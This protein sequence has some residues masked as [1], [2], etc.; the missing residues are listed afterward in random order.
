M[1][2]LALDLL[3]DRRIAVAS[4]ASADRPALAALFALDQRF[5]AIV[6]AARDPLVGQMRLT[7]WHEALTHLDAAP[8]PAEPLLQAIA[9]DLMPRGVSGHAL[10]GL[11]DSWEMLL[12]GMTPDRPT[13]DRYA[14]ARGGALFTMAG[15]LFA[16]APAM[17]APAGQGWALADLAAH[18][19]DPALAAAARE[20]A[21]AALAQALANRWR[22]ARPLG[23]LALL[24][25]LDLGDHGPLAKS[26]IL[27]RFR[28]GGR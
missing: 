8:P 6:R 23:V 1:N 2:D 14:Q 24:A 20:A 7:W 28:L 10:A 26:L 27:T 17:L 3:P 22:A 21:D 4:A 9:A 11:V 5:G 25:R 15:R 16:D 18:S 12:E 19:R 13:L